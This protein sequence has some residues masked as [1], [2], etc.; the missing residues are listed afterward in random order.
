M[1]NIY[2]S[3]MTESLAGNKYINIFM[4]IQCVLKVIISV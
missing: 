1:G 2:T 3:N 4:N